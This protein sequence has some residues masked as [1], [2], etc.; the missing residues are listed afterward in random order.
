MYLAQYS[1]LP[2]C[3]LFYIQLIILW[4]GLYIREWRNMN[5]YV[6]E[7]YGYISMNENKRL[8]KSDNPQYWLIPYFIHSLL[9]Y[10]DISYYYTHY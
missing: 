6:Y 4:Y 3:V 7:Y 8:H 2:F 10:K 5:I 1:R 9:T